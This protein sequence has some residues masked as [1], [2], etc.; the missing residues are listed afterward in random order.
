[1]DG[2]SEEPKPEGGAAGDAKDARPPPSEPGTET[3]DDEDAEMPSQRASEIDPSMA[4]WFKVDKPAE[5]PS[6]S[7]EAPEDSETD[8]DSDYDELRFDEEA[9]E[10]VLPDKSHPVGENGTPSVS[11]RNVDGPFRL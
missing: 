8:P 2:E 5:R 11:L 7:R 6:S 10:W 4:D 1:M 9:E 3:Q